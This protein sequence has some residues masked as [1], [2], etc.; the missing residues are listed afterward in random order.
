[1][2]HKRLIGCGDLARAMAEFVGITSGYRLRRVIPKKAHVSQIRLKK[3]ACV[4]RVPEQVA[5]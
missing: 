4:G 5:S 1:M 2:N 3:S